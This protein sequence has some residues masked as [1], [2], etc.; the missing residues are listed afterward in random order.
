MKYFLAIVFFGLFVQHVGAQTTP[1]IRRLEKERTELRRQIS[2]SETLLQS[3]QKDVKSQLENLALLSDQIDER[4]KYIQT[5]ERDVAS[6]QQEVRRLEVE[7]NGLN[8]NLSARKKRYEHSIR[9]M[10]TRLSIQERLMF[11]FAAEDLNQMYR[12]M[13]Y[14]QQYADF[15]RLQGNQIA[16]KRKEI[17]EKKNVLHQ[18]QKAKQQL[19]A[20]GEVEKQELEGKEQERKILLLNL[21]KKQRSIQNELKSQKRTAD[22]LNDKIDKLIAYE[23][24]R[25]RKRAEADERKRAEKKR[26][27]E[28]TK[29]EQQKKQEAVATARQMADNTG[30]K[31]RESFKEVE[32]EVATSAPVKKQEIYHVDTNDRELSGSFVRNKGRLPIPVTGAYAIIGH[33]GQYQVNGLRHVRLDNKGIDIKTRKGAMAR[34]VFDGEVSAV[35]QFNG[36]N[37]VLVR[38]GNYITVYCNLSSVLVKKGSQLKTRDVIGEINTDADGNTILHFQLRKEVTKLNPELWIHR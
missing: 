25:A 19:L 30:K 7:L 14:M 5:I 15:Q 27:A 16:Q 23:I 3:T 38:H 18:S 36:L 32:P 1:R 37:N 33:Y 8:G 24:E 31:Q 11:I 10:S 2:E 29:R 17:S 28:K 34:T 6:I 12:R 22:Q 26:L 13:R 21:Q 35:F 4:K 9:Y 20:Q